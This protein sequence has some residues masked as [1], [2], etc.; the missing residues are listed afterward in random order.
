MIFDHFLAL[1]FAIAAA[2]SDA[3]FYHKSKIKKTKNNNKKK[4]KEKEKKRKKKK[5]K[6]KKI[7]EM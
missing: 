4:S 2:F 6:K 5:K 7:C 1:F 3:R